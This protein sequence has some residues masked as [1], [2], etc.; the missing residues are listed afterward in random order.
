M[1]ENLNYEQALLKC[2]TIDQSS[3]RSKTK[4]KNESGFYEKYC[5][6]N[7]AFSPNKETDIIFHKE[8]TNIG[9]FITFHKNGSWSF[10]LPGIYLITIRLSFDVGG[11]TNGVIYCYLH[12]EKICNKTNIQYSNKHVTDWTFELNTKINVNKNQL[13]EVFC[14]KTMHISDDDINITLIGNQMSHIN[15]IK[16]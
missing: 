16:V 2:L 10:N 11:S 12:R 15:I 9:K 13:N 7:Q 14:V 1:S 4:N 3:R 8:K 6:T 5:D